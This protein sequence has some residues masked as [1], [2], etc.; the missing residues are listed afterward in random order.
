M[1]CD[2]R[3]TTRGTVPRVPFERI[4]TSI[5][6]PSYTLSLVVCGDTLSKAMNTRYRHK[7]Y[8]PN[9]LSFPLSASEG[10]IFLNVRKA[11]REAQKEHVSCEE[12]IAYL[13]IHACL[14]LKGHK[15]G[16]AMDA[17]EDR[18]MRRFRAR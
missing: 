1:A 4:A 15:H 12:R 10:E 5:V 18:Y 3:N 14:H 6:G 17:L 13:F 7:T 2:I 8:R 9:V 16:D 11:E